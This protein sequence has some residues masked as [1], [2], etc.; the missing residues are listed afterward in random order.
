MGEA[1]A[2]IGSLEADNARLRDSLIRT[3][4][5][6][7]RVSK[8]RFEAVRRGQQKDREIERLK[9]SLAFYVEDQKVEYNKSEDLL[10]KIEDLNNRLKV[11]RDRVVPEDFSGANVIYVDF[12]DSLLALYGEPALP[13]PPKV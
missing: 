3:D 5:E 7:C 10:C 13:D 2:R 4:N 1:M 8:L 11:L 9:A 6:N 12:K